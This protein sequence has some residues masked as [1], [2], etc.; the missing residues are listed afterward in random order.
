MNKQ[1]INFIKK[2]N[3]SD[4]EIGDI[5]NISPMMEVITYEEFMENVSILT[6]YGYPEEDLDFLLLANPYL[7][8]GSPIDLEAALLKLK[9]RDENIEEI[10]KKNPTII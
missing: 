1:I 10:L 5:V 8:S 2:Y 6:K 4:L 9:N 3:I 7:F